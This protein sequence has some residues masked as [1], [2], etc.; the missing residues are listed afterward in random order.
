MRQARRCEQFALRLEMHAKKEATEVHERLN[1]DAICGI[2]KATEEGCE[3]QED[4]AINISK[5]NINQCT[6]AL[7]IPTL[8]KA[9]TKLHSLYEARKEEALKYQT[10]KRF[11]G[12]RSKVNY[13]KLQ[14]KNHASTHFKTLKG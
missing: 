1:K 4:L 12:N 9:A 7:L 10:K 2:V 13:L 8:K 14:R 11:K 5:K 3:W 6:N